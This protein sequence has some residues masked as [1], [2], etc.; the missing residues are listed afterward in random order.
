MTSLSSP[1][2]LTSSLIESVRNNHV[3][4]DS[5]PENVASLAIL[6][7]RESLVEALTQAD[8]AIQKVDVQTLSQI[9]ESS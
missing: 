2:S 9:K 5:V 7:T 4:P 1:S 6:T 3:P 8:Y